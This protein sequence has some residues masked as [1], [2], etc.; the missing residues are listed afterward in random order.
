MGSA[1]LLA[2][3]E[4]ISADSKDR[5]SIRGDVHIESMTFNV[6]VQSPVCIAGGAFQS[7]SSAII[8][9]GEYR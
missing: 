8:V 3:L 5:L 1:D 7:S 9:G 2:R 4:G 6:H